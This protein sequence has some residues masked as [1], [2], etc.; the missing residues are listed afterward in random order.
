VA[1]ANMAGAHLVASGF[2]EVTF[3]DLGL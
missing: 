3:A 2:T 1:R